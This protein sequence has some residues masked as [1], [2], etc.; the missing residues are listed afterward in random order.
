MKISRDIYPFKG[1]YLDLNGLRLH[2][3]DEGNGDPVVMVHGNPTWSIYYRNLVHALKRSFRTIVPDHMGCGFSDKPDDAQ[4]DYSLTRRID[5]LE[6]LLTHLKITDKITL[7]MHDW[8]G[9]IGM[10]YAARH[11]ENICRLVILNTSAFHKPEGKAF[12]SLLR[13]CR[14][15]EIG[16][17]LVYRHNAFSRLAARMCCKRRSMSKE[18]REAYIAP[19][20]ENSIATLR[21]VQDIPLRPGDRSYETVTRIQ[22]A[23]QLFEELPILVCWGEKDFVF[24]EHFLRKWI[25]IFPRAQ[26]HRFPDCGHYVLEDAKEEIEE[27]VQTFLKNHPN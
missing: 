25:R 8:G 3:L 17:F 27:L 4:Y 7:V 15:T 1:S 24:D 5:D 11:P 23:L 9:M 13:L 20:A 14:N 2:Y 26:V 10:G 21:F 6:V 22:E 16:S 19:Y 18:I 12:P